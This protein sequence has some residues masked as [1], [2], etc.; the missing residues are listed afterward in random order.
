MGEV[1][2]FEND[3]KKAIEYFQKASELAEMYR[4]MNIL[5]SSQAGLVQSYINVGDYKN[6]V[7]FGR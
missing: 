7:K 5:T 2:N 3:F 1:N 6:S 4:L